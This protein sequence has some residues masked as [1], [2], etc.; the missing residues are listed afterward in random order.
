MFRKIASKYQ[1]EFDSCEFPAQ[2]T[3]IFNIM[4]MKNSNWRDWKRRHLIEL[5]AETLITA[6]AGRSIF[7]GNFWQQ[8][9]FK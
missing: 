2:G 6:G 5:A 1:A 3:F 7:S 9:L 8:A 4:A